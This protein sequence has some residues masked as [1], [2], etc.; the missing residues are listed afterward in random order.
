M[1]PVVLNSF[2]AFT[3]LMP[4]NGLNLKKKQNW[5]S[6]VTFWQVWQTMINSY[7]PDLFF[8]PGVSFLPLRCLGRCKI[9]FYENTVN[10]SKV[11]MVEHYLEIKNYI[12]LFYDKCQL[13]IFDTLILGLEWYTSQ[14]CCQYQYTIKGA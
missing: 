2:T 11:V 7:Q 5:V 9:L 13:L 14:N 8:S 10:S 6:I 12:A 4:C 3:F 1:L